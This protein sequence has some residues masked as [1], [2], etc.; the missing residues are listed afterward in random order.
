MVRPSIL[1]NFIVIGAMRAGTTTLYHHLRNHPDIGMSRTK[2]TDFFV[3]AM[4]YPLGFDWYHRQFT[5]GY[6]VYGE[7][8]PNYAKHDLWKGVPELIKQA[9]PE[10][11][12]IF[13]AR[14]PVDR[15]VSHYLHSWHV[16]HTSVRPEHLLG[17]GNGQHMLETSRYAAQLRIYL[18]HFPR[19]RILIL[20]FDELR[21]DAQSAVNRAT[22]FWTWAGIPSPG[23]RSAT[24]RTPSPDCPRRAARLAQPDRAALRRADHAARCGIGR[25]GCCRSARGAPIRRSVPDIRAEAAERLAADTA[26][27]REMSG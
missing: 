4:N 17:S 8:S 11:R 27:F 23:S 25:D 3:T 21:T 5:P 1:P 20:D 14:D 19:N 18:D 22:D 7:V 16:G 10:V 9:A 13:I 26:E 24:T 12:L 15:F 2:E 6:S